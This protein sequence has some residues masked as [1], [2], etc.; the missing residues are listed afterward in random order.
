[1]QAAFRPKLRARGF[2]LLTD[3]TFEIRT[4]RNRIHH[5]ARKLQKLLLPPRSLNHPPL[6]DRAHDIE[7][8]DLGKQRPGVSTLRKL[9]SISQRSLDIS[10]RLARISAVAQQKPQSRDDW[11]FVQ[12]STDLVDASHNL[13][14]A[15]RDL[16]EISGTQIRSSREFVDAVKV[17]ANTRLALAEAMRELAE[18]SR[19]ISEGMGV[20]VLD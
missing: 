17:L 6:D 4:S 13:V 18:V 20:V 10:L 16:V 14:E 9:A 1:M 3:E 12:A 11:N 8:L 2:I 5:L 7:L 15:S 19:G